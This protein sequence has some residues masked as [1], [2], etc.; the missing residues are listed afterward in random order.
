MV[1]I[2][3]VSK[4]EVFYVN[5]QDLNSLMDRNLRFSRSIKIK[6]SKLLNL[7]LLL[8]LCL[9]MP[10]LKLKIKFRPH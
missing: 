5:F 1:N 6:V 3:K 2:T 7:S 4:F 8:N 10:L 9:N